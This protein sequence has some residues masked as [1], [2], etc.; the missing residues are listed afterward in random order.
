MA[1]KSYYDLLHLPP[2]AS[3]DDVK[4]AFRHQ[5]ARYHPDKVQHLGTEF[6]ALA[7]D[8]AAELTE[9]YRILSNATLR[10]EYDRARGDL[11]APT[12]PVSAS[13]SPKPT[14]PTPSS[15]PAEETPR[16]ANTQFAGDRVN[17][18]E[19]VRRATIGRVRQALTTTFGPF[20]ESP[21]RGFDLV[22]VPKPKRFSR[23]RPPRLLVRFVPRV[24]GLAV[25]EAWAQAAKWNVPPSEEVCLLLMGPSLGSARELADAIHEQR[26]KPTR[27]G[28]LTLIPVNTRDWAAH[29]PLD[30]PAVAKTVLEQLRARV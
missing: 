20:D 4:R 19:F 5:I 13:E 9:A 12:P 10:E 14:Q 2:T 16:P 15:P 25:S 17:S 11:S 28:K 3:A 29:I 24:D 18:D 27:P 7:A 8:R 30:A 6:Q 26:R 22:C 21:V 23:T 1:A